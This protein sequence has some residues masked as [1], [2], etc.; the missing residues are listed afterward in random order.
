M[1]ISPSHL[2]EPRAGTKQHLFKLVTDSL[3]RDRARSA[4]FNIVPAGDGSNGRQGAGGKKWGYDNI[5]APG[6]E[7]RRPGETDPGRFR[8][9]RHIAGTRT[10][11]WVLTHTPG[12]TYRFNQIAIPKCKGCKGTAEILCQTCK[13]TRR[14]PA[15]PARLAGPCPDCLRTPH[16]VFPCP[17]CCPNGEKP[18]IVDGASIS[19]KFAEW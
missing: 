15:N 8:I 5:L 3:Y 14:L 9:Y 7:Q 1:P 19:K 18:V 16:S 10:T 4:T 12:N 2:P 11:W 17:E 13:G 6:T